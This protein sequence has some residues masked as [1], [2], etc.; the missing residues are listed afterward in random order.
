[1]HII[2]S[3]KLGSCPV[4]ECSVAIIISSAHRQESLLAIQFTID[5]L[6]KIVPIWKKEHYDDGLTNW[7]SNATTTTT[8]SSTVS[9]NTTTDIASN[10]TATKANT[11]SEATTTN[12]IVVSDTTLKNE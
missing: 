4:S 7:K 12:D 8:T 10:D 1:L 6:K 3:H 11:I 5:E 2:I 9:N